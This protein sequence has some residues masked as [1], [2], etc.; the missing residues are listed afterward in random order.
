MIERWLLYD[1]GCSLCAAL[2]REV[3]ALSE[4]RLRMRSLREPEVQ[5]LLDRARPG[6]RWEPMLL[7]EEGERVRVYTGL[8]MRMQLVRVLGPARALRVAQL[9]ARF[10]GPVLGVDWGRRRLLQ[11][12]GAL[13]GL[14]LLGRWFSLRPRPA[15]SSSS[16]LRSKMEGEVW[17]GF[18]LLPAGAPLPAWVRS[19]P[20]YYRR[21]RRVDLYDYSTN[22]YVGSVFYG[23]LDEA[24][25]QQGDGWATLL[26]SNR[27][28]LGK[29]PGCTKCT[30]TCCC[31]ATKDSGCCFSG[32]HAHI[33]MSNGQ[34]ASLACGQT[35]SEGTTLLYSFQ[36]YPC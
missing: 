2:A 17:E 3:E 10:G 25:G 27:L 30:S 22:C 29:I 16:S 23:H 11:Q 14:A 31:G 32:S 7:E 34:R 20:T 21:I 33:G 12:G 4:G 24:V 18:L 36:I 9:V 28:L 35:V 13:A 1:A 8:A 19:S 26:T 5:A 15:S 6:W